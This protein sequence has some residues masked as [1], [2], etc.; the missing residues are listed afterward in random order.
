MG[1]TAPVRVPDWQRRAAGWL[2]ALSLINLIANV[3]IILTGGAVRL[4]GSGLGCPTWPRCTD[5]SYVAHPELGIHGA[6][7]FGNRMLTFVLVA[8]VVSCWVAALGHRAVTGAGRPLRLATVIALGVPA[9]AVIGG[10]SVLTDLDPWVVALHLLVSLAM[11]A[12]CVALLAEANPAWFPRSGEDSLR[13]LI[14]ATYALVWLVLYLGT[15]VTG[16]GP[17]AGDA[18]ARRNGLD[19]AAAS[20]V[21][22]A[23][24]YTLV[25]I[26]LLLVV[27]ARRRG[28]LILVRSAGLLLVV[29]LA[30]GVVGIIQVRTGLPE[31]L[32]GLHLFG[33]ALTIAAATRLLIATTRLPAQRDGDA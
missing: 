10:V 31:L 17:H 6:I 29:E 20:H 24:V 25:A 22:A 12:L 7:E 33:A 18:S 32:V 28:D 4:T 15:V 14:L 2:T 3:G 13:R 9:Q 16:S 21:H 27:L 30:Q 1:L 11:V 19:S 23:A 5:D 8:V 26:T